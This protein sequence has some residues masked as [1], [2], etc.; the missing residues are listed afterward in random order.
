MRKVYQ[1]LLLT[2]LISNT[3]AQE[4]DQEN[5]HLNF[6]NQDDYF[7]QLGESIANPFLESLSWDTLPDLPS[8]SGVKSFT[9]N[10]INLGIAFLPFTLISLKGFDESWKNSSYE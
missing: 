4:T 1:I 6:A 8:F 5:T 9:L 10:S 2:N 3:I 7:Y